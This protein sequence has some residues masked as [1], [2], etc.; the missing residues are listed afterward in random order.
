MKI[1]RFV[2]N[3]MKEA[4]ELIRDALGSEAVIVSSR[5]IREKGL[6]GFFKP[7]K[8]E[9]TAAIEEQFAEEALKQ[10]LTQ[11]KQL[12]ADKGL[13]TG[14]EL[15]KEPGHSRVLID[16]LQKALSRM[17]MPAE[18]VDYLINRITRKKMPLG[19]E[20]LKEMLL[21]EMEALFTPVIRKKTSNKIVVVGPT[22]VGKTTTLVKLGAIFS[23]FEGRK[24]G[25]ITLDTY[26]VGAI[27]QL[28]IYGDIIGVPVEVVT[29]QDELKTAVHKNQDKDLILIDTAGRSSRNVY[30]IAELKNLLDVIKPVDIYLTL[31]CASREPEL[32]KM[33]NNFKN[34]NYCGLIFTKIDEAENYSAILKAAYLTKLPIVYITNGQEGS[35]KLL[36]IGSS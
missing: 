4:C 24:I 28:K 1:R 21:Q 8:L 6:A 22:G 5:K 23:L 16:K 3:D 12:L 29:N 27:E 10:E 19:E 18:L 11:I 25:F 13:S 26:R 33:L 36:I 34:L 20:N 32:I 14:G 30:N 35:I 17:E 7:Q 15:A 31:S 9:V 2:A